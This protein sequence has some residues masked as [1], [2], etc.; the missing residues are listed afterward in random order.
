MT[1][2][3]HHLAK[4]YWIANSKVKK[5][6]VAV[7]KQ[8]VYYV[9]YAKVNN[10][11]YYLNSSWPERSQTELKSIILNSI[12]YNCWYHS[13]N[14]NLFITIKDYDVQ[15]PSILIYPNKF[16]CYVVN[17]LAFIQLFWKGISILTP[18]KYFFKANS[19]PNARVWE[20]QSKVSH[21]F[22]WFKNAWHWHSIQKLIVEKTGE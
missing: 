20:Q 15:S 5:Y 10:A 17:T 13:V 2:A 19:D 4:Y 16:L 7:P 1:F 8:Q 22:E 3:I 12:R 11:I 6:H 21:C 9:M 18:G 14:R